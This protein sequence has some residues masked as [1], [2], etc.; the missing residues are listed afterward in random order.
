MI[1][2]KRTGLSCT[3]KCQIF[4]CKI[5]LIFIVFIFQWNARTWLV[6]ALLIDT[7]FLGYCC[8][9]DNNCT[10]FLEYCCKVENTCTKFIIRI[11]KRRSNKFCSFVYYFTFSDLTFQCSVRNVKCHLPKQYY[12]KTVTQSPNEKDNYP[13]EF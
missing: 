6:I 12:R 11:I 2:F 9:V 5:L 7:I 8:K 10:I 3:Q 13:D 1:T 4:I